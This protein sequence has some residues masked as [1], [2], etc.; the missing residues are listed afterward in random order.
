MSRFRCRFSSQQARRPRST[1][2]S[3]NSYHL[4]R[5]MQATRPKGAAILVVFAR[6]PV[7]KS[8]ISKGPQQISPLCVADFINFYPI[9]LPLVD[10]SPHGQGLPAQSVHFLSPCLRGTIK[11]YHHRYKTPHLVIPKTPLVH[12][13]Y[14]LDHLK[15]H[16]AGLSH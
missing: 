10:C 5:Q 6:R 4:G 11:K 14:H 3:I 13:S 12:K 2:D 7:D 8:A 9:A 15:P 1:P 16:L